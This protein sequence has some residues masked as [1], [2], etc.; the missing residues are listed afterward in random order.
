[1]AGIVWISRP[2]AV[3]VR[4]RGDG[5][6]PATLLRAVCSWIAPRR[7]AALVRAWSAKFGTRADSELISESAERALAGSGSSRE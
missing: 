7:V 4:A 5:P 3:F 2:R 1:M 6:S